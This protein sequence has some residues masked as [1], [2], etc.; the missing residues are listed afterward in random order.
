MISAKEQAA[1]LALAKLTAGSPGPASRLIQASGSALRLMDGDVVGLRKE[2]RAYAADLLSRLG[3]GDLA[4]AQEALDAGH[5]AGARLVTVLE[6]E[7]PVNLAAVHNLPPFLWVRGEL[8]PREYHAIAIAG[9]E[10]RSIPLARRAAI[11]LAHAGITV[12]AGSACDLD[13]AVHEAALA[14]G[15]RTLSVLDHGIGVPARD[16]GLAARIA[17]AGAVVS[18]C[19][20]GDEVSAETTLRAAVLTSG[21][22]V[23]VFLVDGQDGSRPAAQGRIALNH[24]KNLLVPHRLH[25]EQPWLRRLARRGGVSVVADIDE[26]LSQAVNSISVL[27]ILMKR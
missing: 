22:A 11:A 16:E 27:R 3:P 19:W 15:G 12:V 7:Y 17:Q 26:L 6:P 14:A 25:R 5:S 2:R 9:Q 1:V 18:S 8:R 21:L 4:R 23:D 10:P 20:P 13:L 24:G